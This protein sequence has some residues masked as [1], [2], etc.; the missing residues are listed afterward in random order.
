MSVA[1]RPSLLRISMFSAVW[2]VSV[3]AGWGLLAVAG[4]SVATSSL[5]AAGWPL[6]MTAVLLVVLELLPLV[7]GRG[8]DPQGVVMSTAFVCG[9]LFL[10]GIWP[11]VLVVSIAAFASDVNVRKSPWKLLFNIGQY[12]LSVAAG[13]LVMRLSHIDPSLEHPLGHFSG[14]DLG[15]M[16]GVWVAYFVTNDVLVSG[17]LAW[18]DSFINMLL[19]DFAHYTITT[20]SVLALSPLIVVLGQT[21]WEIMPLL[22]IPLLLVYKTAQ[23]SLDKEHQA[24]HDSLTGLPNRKSL[25]NAL[26]ESLN[27]SR[28]DEQPFGLLLIDLD[29]FKEVN[30]TLGHHVGD[31]I[32]IHFADRLRASVRDADHVAR[33]GGDEFAVIVA[34][35]EESEVRILAERIRNSLVDPIAHD[36]MLFDIEASIGIAMHPEQGVRPDDLLRLADVAMYDA[37]ETRT[38]IA[39]YAAARDRHSADRLGLLGELRQALDDDG[40]ELH[41]QPKV[42]MRDSS[43]MGMEALVR[44]EHPSRGFISPEEFIPLAERSGIM[45]LLTERVIELALRQLSRWRSEG[46]PVPVAVNVSVSDLAGPHLIELVSRGLKDNFLTGG[47]LQLEI[48]ERVV[49]DDSLN[50]D[51]V[52]RTLAEMGVSLSLDDF[53]TGYSSLLRLQSLPVDEIKIDRA[54]VSR[55]GDDNDGSGIVR[56]VIDL[57]HARGLPAIAEGVETAQEWEVLRLLGCDGAQ[58]WHIAAPMP[59]ADATEWM[60]KRIALTG[61]VIASAAKC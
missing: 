36:G 58:G 60:R 57:A 30:D 11:A 29:H 21:D 8:H 37:K 2:W 41:Y 25:H 51:S 39:S 55:L 43:V 32:L 9:M 12:N 16:I 48:T 40:I 54:F 18:T 13:W 24:G 45:T 56:A 61:T 28:R 38:G 15:W 4:R 59:A 35:A 53:G 3:L 10:W 34:D 5:T 31:Q 22:L 17:V 49:A 6:A 42:A 14:R 47:M 46:L 44:W 52:F 26:E 1:E 50:L 33:L 19:D 7:Q 20:F 27:R 23:M